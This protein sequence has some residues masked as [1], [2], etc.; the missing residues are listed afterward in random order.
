MAD[1]LRWHDQ[2][3]QV[4]L[5]SESVHDPRPSLPTGVGSIDSLL[6]RG[7]LLPGSF[8]LLG[9]RTGTRKT[10]VALNL[11]VSMAQA[12]IPVGFVGLDE[13]PW[14]YSL[15]FLS[16]WSGYSQDW[17][18]RNWDDPEAQQLQRDW[19]LFAKDRV[20]LFSGRRPD[21]SDLNGQIE[22][23]S[24]GTGE[25]PR[26]IVVDYLNL[27]T[28]GREYGWKETDRIPRIAEDLA[29]WST[30]T[31]I[32]VVALHQLARNDEFGG[33]NN[34]N[35]GH[36]PVTL[37]QLKYGGEEPA[38]MVLS[39]YRPSMNPVALMSLPAAKM[40][41]GDRFDEED[42]WEIRGIAEKYKRSTFLQ[43][44]KNRPGT[45]REERGVELISPND[46]LVLREENAHDPYQSEE[47]EETQDGQ[48][49]TARR[50]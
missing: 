35:A 27:M 10:T 18:E 38:D 33:A 49:E 46:S 22:M 9:G 39:T 4:E 2:H 45:H 1:G 44:L 48:P 8:T 25:A 34:R 28:R 43:L 19:K 31:G 11:L 42:Y 12:D 13:P 20:H 17:L 30:E 40:A 3:Q 36:L 16:V 5:V 15:K 41:L 6:R 50:G 23:T 47:D 29:L 7:G 32:A 37:A 21:L 26:I 14:M 24:M